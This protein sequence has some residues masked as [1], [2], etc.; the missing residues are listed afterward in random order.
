[1]KKQV[2]LIIILIV[3]ISIISLVV[4]N[5]TYAIEGNVTDIATGES[6]AGVKAIVANHEGTTDDKGH[7]KIK[8]IKL[9]QKGDLTINVP[10]GYIDVN[11]IKIDYGSRFIRKDFT[12]EPTLERVVTLVNI[13]L[14]NNQYDYVWDFI[15]PDVKKYW[16]SKDE[17]VTLN[18]LVADVIEQRILRKSI[19]S[20]TISGNIRTLDSWK[21]KTI[22][23]DKEY[24]DVLEVPVEIVYIQNGKEQPQTELFYYQRVDG[25][26]HFFASV[27]KDSLKEMVKLYDVY[28]KVSDSELKSI[29]INSEKYINK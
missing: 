21:F 13:A 10:E 3:S 26:Y 25:F 6:V 27:D 18:K 1:M 12:I 19:K 7:Y 9:Y 15:H 28:N 20:I 11:P 8:G 24:K 5:L 16:D 2:L 22:N 14:K 23:P 4:F 17:Y 29:Y